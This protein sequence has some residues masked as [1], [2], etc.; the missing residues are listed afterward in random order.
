MLKKLKRRFVAISMLLVGIVLIFFYLMTCSVIIFT[1]NS[2]IENVLQDYSSMTIIDTFHN[3]GNRELDDNLLAQFSGNVCVVS[4][5]EITGTIDIL[6]FSRARMDNTVLE[7]AVNIVMSSDNEFG[8]IYSLNLFYYRNQS[9]LGTKIAFADSTQ[10]IT[11]LQELM[12]AGGIIFVG[13]LVFLFIISNILANMS[14]KPVEKAWLQQQNFIADASHE[15]K[16]PLT[17]ILTNGN[18]LQSHKNETIDDQMKWI[19][20]TNEE[21]SHM[22]DLVD[23]LLLLAK[24]DNMRQNNLF[25]DVDL[26]EVCERASLQFEPVAY[27]KGVEL[28]TMIEPGVQL[29]G[30]A[31]A[32]NQILHILLDN[33]VKYAGLGG[34]VE[35]SMTKKQNY[36]YLSVKNTGTPIPPEDIPHIFERFFRSDKARTSGS[37]YGLGLA[38]CKNLAELHK[39]DISVTSNAL[40]GTLFTV[41]FRLNFH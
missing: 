13:A 8:N 14:L 7:N 21:A 11:Y 3:I 30:D 15:L 9:I 6:D 36:A 5:S 23:K 18:I 2:D 10:Y 34:T 39:A 41:R 4:V 19:E 28:K 33:A 37:G 20:S 32:L 1:V 38:I 25:S 22:K 17:V 40:T 29:K 24:T 31:T 26:S 27:E 12:I 16:T 35:L